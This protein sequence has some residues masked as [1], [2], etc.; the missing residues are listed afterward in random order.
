MDWLEA[1]GIPH[2]HLSP[3]AMQRKGNVKARCPRCRRKNALSIHMTKRVWNCHYSACGWSGAADHGTGRNPFFY[4]KLER[5]V[6]V[7]LPEDAGEWGDQ[8]M[9]EWRGISAETLRDYGVTFTVEP[10]PQPIFEYTFRGDPVNT[11]RRWV[12]PDGKKGFN[13]EGG[14]ILVPFGY[15]QAIAKLDALGEEETMQVVLCEGEIDALSCVEA[16]W[17]AISMPNGANKNMEWA[18]NAEPLL[19][20]PKVEVILAVDDDV[21]GASIEGMLADML[22]KHRCWRVSYPDGCKDANEVLQA[23]DASVLRA[24]LLTA[25]RYPVEGIIKPETVYRDLERLYRGM[26]TE[27]I[28][29]TGWHALDS[30]WTFAEGQTTLFYGVP[31]AGKSEFVDNLIVNLCRKYNYHATIFS[32]EYFPPERY[33]AKWIE[34]YSGGNFFYGDGRISEQELPEYARWVNNH[35]TVLM[36]DEFSVDALLELA[37]V[38]VYRNQSKILLLDN[39]SAMVQDNDRITETKWIG[40]ELTK[41]QMWGRNHGCAV[42]IVNHPTK[43]QRMTDGSNNYVRPKPYDMSGSAQWYNKA[44]SILCIWRDTYDGRNP[45]EVIVQKIRY[46][47]VGIEGTA[48]F[49]FNRYNSTYRD[50]GAISLNGDRYGENVMLYKPTQLGM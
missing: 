24:C 7:P 34:K 11:K 39:W 2:D 45:V 49:E 20:S 21:S 3:G 40:Q 1:A 33:I 38:E 13:T 28:K 8:A 4:E 42:F 16:G 17:T 5:K 30:L 48:Y 43:M 35:M 37:E 44:D 50:R 41:L 32:P 14:S 27:K 47:E 29:P 36:P 31:G 9:S 19:R 10:E 26:G 46:K 18:Q 6:P 12:S 22:G 25:D 23:H 15:D